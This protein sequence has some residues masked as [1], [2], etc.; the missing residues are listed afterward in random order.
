[1]CKVNIN[2]VSI[3]LPHQIYT[4]NQINRVEVSRP[5]QLKWLKTSIDSSMAKGLSG[6]G[7]VEEGLL[8]S[9]WVEGV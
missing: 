4:Q 9:S 1:M 5:I 8:L 7:K 2:I 3:T 6:W